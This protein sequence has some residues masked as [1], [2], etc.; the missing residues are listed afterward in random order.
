MSLFLHLGSSVPLHGVGG[1]ADPGAL[2]TPTVGQAPCPVLLRG[3]HDGAVDTRQRPCPVTSVSSP[4][5]VPRP[6]TGRPSWPHSLGT[7]GLWLQLVTL[8]GPVAAGA[9]RVCPGPVCPP[10]LLGVRPGCSRSFQ[11]ARL[12]LAGVSTCSRWAGR[13]P[14]RSGL[15]WPPP[16]GLWAGGHKS[17]LKLGQDPWAPSYLTCL[18]Q[19]VSL[20]AA[21]GSAMAGHCRPPAG[22]PVGHPRAGCQAP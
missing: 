8:A 9:L 14:H 21:Q 16:P 1:C 2:S 15:S 10:R 11:S 5:R 12:P 3:R 17:L 19:P 7:T 20:S 4:P 22:G 6:H 13:W 18:L